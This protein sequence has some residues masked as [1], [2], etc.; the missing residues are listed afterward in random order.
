VPIYEYG[1]QECGESQ[2]VCHGMNENPKIKCS[3]CGS[4]KT[5]RIIKPC[6]FIMRSTRLQTKIMDK[7]K[8]NKEIKDDL[9]EAHGIHDFKP[10]ATNSME[11]I[12]KDVKD[13]KTLVHEKMQEEKEKNQA[14]TKIK[15]R[16]WMRGALKRTKKRGEERIEKKKKEEAKK[17]KINL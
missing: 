6:N 9:R 13:N 14:K 17:R 16:E 1:C 10:I 11:K 4:K 8:R 12:Y 3:N 7:G 2:E 15:Q 5:E